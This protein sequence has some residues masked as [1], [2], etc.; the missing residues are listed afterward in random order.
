MEALTGPVLNILMVVIAG[1]I[2]I[3]WLR[4]AVEVSRTVRTELP[5][6]DNA[7]AEHIF[8][9]LLAEA[10]AELVI[11]DDGDA[12]EGS[13]YQSPEVVEALRG[14]LRA[15][16]SFRVEC[17]LNETGR[18]LF[19]RELARED[20]VRIRRRGSDPSRVHYKIIDKRKAYVSC[21]EPGE[22]AR[23]RAMI[24]CSNALSRR[25]GRPPLAL[26]RYFDDFERHAA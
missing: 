24:D 5:P 18:T 15:N 7:E 19:E 23:N 26:R 11:Y 2:S 20:R 17:V 8:L 25:R 1:L 3:P 4:N 10:K 9:D 14:K 22:V 12:A 21:H 16:A 13:L 6:N